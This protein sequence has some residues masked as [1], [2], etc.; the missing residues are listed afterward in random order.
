MIFSLNFSVVSYSQI[1]QLVRLID[2]F[3]S[4]FE[5]ESFI[6]VSHKIKIETKVVLKKNC[7]SEA[8]AILLSRPVLSPSHILIYSQNILLIKHNLFVILVL[9][10]P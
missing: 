3:I 10:K 8:N 1:G 4:P 6:A 9:C 2:N 7:K 5:S